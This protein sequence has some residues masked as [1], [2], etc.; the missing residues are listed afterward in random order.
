[1]S[2]GGAQATLRTLGVDRIARSSADRSD[3]IVAS[4]LRDAVND[5][6]QPSALG[7]E[8]HNAP[9]GVLELQNRIAA[10][11]LADQPSSEPQDVAARLSAM[12]TALQAL[13]ARKIAP[14]PANEAEHI[15]TRLLLQR[16]QLVL[17]NEFTEGFGRLEL[18]L[19]SAAALALVLLKDLD[20]LWLVPVLALS[21]GRSWILDRQCRQRR[22]LIANIDAIVGDF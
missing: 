20:F 13:R 16:E 10:A 11:F 3:A 9:T 8:Q 4:P 15:K 12:T 2:I 19:V 7:T 1:M 21:V 6:F 5:D 14:D 18:G 17:A 22:Q